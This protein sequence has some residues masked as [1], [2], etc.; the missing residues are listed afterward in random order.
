MRILRRLDEKGPSIDR[1]G[2]S[3]SEGDDTAG[4]RARACDN[5]NMQSSM[6]TPAGCDPGAANKEKR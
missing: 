4:H 5:F 6:F 2:T 1:A 3:T